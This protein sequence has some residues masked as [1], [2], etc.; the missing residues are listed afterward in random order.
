MMNVKVTY[1]DD[2][3]SIRSFEDQ[4]RSN[5][6]ETTEFQAWFYWTLLYLQKPVQTK[7]GTYTLTNEPKTK[8][9]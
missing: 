2:T 9:K 1:H 5:E 3:F 8:E 4:V 7:F 6:D